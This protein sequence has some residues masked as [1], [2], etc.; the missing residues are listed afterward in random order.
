MRR[1][2][3]AVAAESWIARNDPSRAFSTAELWQGLCV[4][5]PDLTTPSDARK[6]PRSTCM[7]DLRK[8]GRFSVSG[9]VVRLLSVDGGTRTS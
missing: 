9:G 7:R 5:R 4:E 1:S 6:T 3:F 2:P 8:D